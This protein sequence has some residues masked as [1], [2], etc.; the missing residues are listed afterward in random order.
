MKDENRNEEN[1]NQEVD[2]ETQNEVEENN[3]ESQAQ[4]SNEPDFKDKYARLLAEFT[5]FQRQKDEEI[6]SMAKFGNSNLLS[7]VIDILD[8][9]E[10]GLVQE[11]ISEETKNILEILKSTKLDT[12][13]NFCEENC[14]DLNQFLRVNRKF[15][16]LQHKTSCN[17]I[18]PS[19]IFTFVLV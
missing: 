9:I 19:S 6:K 13:S 17:K 16:L 8:D 14:S 5:N 1:L 15:L 18:C 10:M 12:M 11:N 2:K 4:E 7:K 3:L